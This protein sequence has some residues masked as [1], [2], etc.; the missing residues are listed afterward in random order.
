MASVCLMFKK[1]T[2]AKHVSRP[3]IVGRRVDMPC[4]D[5]DDLPIHTNTEYWP[6]IIGS[7]IHINIAKA[8]ADT[9]LNWCDNYH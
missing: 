1:G 7:N 4:H 3:T 9:D 8:D 2:E 5:T 6:T